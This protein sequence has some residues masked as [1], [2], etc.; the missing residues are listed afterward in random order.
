MKRQIADRIEDL[1]L[2][3]LVELA[4]IIERQNKSDATEAGTPRVSAFSVEESKEYQEMTFKI[5][6][7]EINAARQGGA[8]ARS[9]GAPK[10][11]GAWNNDDHGRVR[12]HSQPSV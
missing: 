10:V 2:D 5:Y 6:Q 12:E 11:L 4:D 1:D 9:G 3:K 7:L 8:S